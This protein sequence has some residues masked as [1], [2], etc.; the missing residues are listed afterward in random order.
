LKMDTTAEEMIAVI[1]IQAYQ[2]IDFRN[3]NIDP[4]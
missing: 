2:G 4:H 3:S 1:A